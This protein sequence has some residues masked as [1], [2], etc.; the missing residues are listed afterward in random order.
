MIKPKTDLN[1]EIRRLESIDDLKRGGFFFTGYESDQMYRV[2]KSE[3][4]DNTVISLRLE[5]RDSPY[6]KRWART[7]DDLEMQKEVA[8]Q[9]LSWGAF[10]GESLVGVALLE[11]RH[12]N[13]S[14]HLHD[15]EVMPGFR[16]LGVGG[17][18]MDKTLETARAEKVRVITLETQTTNYPAVKFYRRHGYQIDGVDLS[19]YTNHDIPDG[20]VALTMKLK[21]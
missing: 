5:K 18:L 15:L 11:L 20:E 21:L 10:S 19:F 13:N 1:A 9:G 3:T 17:M 7:R 6:V 12:W 16:G 8:A 4:E 2:E 14:L